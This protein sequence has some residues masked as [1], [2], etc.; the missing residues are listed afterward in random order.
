MGDLIEY[1]GAVLG[2]LHFREEG[3]WILAMENVS[4]L[5]IL[6]GLQPSDTIKIEGKEE[7]YENF[8]KEILEKTHTIYTSQKD[9]LSSEAPF[10][11]G[12]KIL[13]TRLD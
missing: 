1:N 13:R 11:L 6:L 5:E 4:A 12:N 8:R 3:G 10:P 9:F 2:N 7:A